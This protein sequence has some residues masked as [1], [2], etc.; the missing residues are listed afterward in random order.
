MLDYHHRATRSN[1][2]QIRTLHLYCGVFSPLK[3]QWWWKTLS[4]AA[5]GERKGSALGCR[6]RYCTVAL[7]S[8]MLML[9]IPGKDS[10]LKGVPCRT[11]K[12][13][14]STK[15]KRN[16]SR[17]EH[18]KTGRKRWERGQAE[19]WIQNEFNQPQEL[20]TYIYLVL[21]EERQNQSWHKPP[22]AIDFDSMCECLHVCIYVC[23]CVKARDSCT[24]NK[25][26]KNIS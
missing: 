6:A 12:E 10:L 13:P 19:C 26:N 2:W 24:Q 23:V 5:L 16:S 14:S 17:L 3:S 15:E 7:Q 1:T 22:T 20:I 18:T 4:I 25:N 21:G 8:C 9:P 11:S